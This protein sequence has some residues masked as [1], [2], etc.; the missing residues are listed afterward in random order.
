MK[1]MLRM[2]EREYEGLRSHLFPP[3]SIIEEAAFLFVTAKIGEMVRFEV[4]AIEKLSPVDFEVQA[5][6]FLEM[7]SET[8]ARLIKRAHDS[9]TSLVEVHSHPG[10]YLATFSEA[11][12]VGLAE[13]V[14]H[15]WW[16]LSKRPYA[17]IVFARTGFDALVW[18]DSPKTAQ[19]LDAL[20][21]GKHFLKPTNRTIM[22]GYDEFS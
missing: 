7:R 4:E 11:D 15:M 21:V 18:L 6:D 1:I 22:E 20:I 19:A 9:G 17:A 8:R 16:R 14:P 10:P 3:R 12:R 5:E 13:T 2:S